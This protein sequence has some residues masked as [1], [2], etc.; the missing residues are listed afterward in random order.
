LTKEYAVTANSVYDIFSNYV[1]KIS[2]DHIKNITIRKMKDMFISEC[3]KK[4]M[5]PATVTS[6]EITNRLWKMYGK[7][8]I[9]RNF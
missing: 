9:N 6:A 3:E 2:T 1:N 8:N 7:Y 4:G 5:K